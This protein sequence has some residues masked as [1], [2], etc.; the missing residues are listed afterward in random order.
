MTLSAEQILFIR[1]RIDASD[2]R[3]V[4]LKEDVLDHLCCI[5][6]ERMSAGESF[7]KAL[8][9]AL[10]QL[11]PEGLDEIQYETDY[12]FK[13]NTIPMKKFMYSIGLVTS[14]S[15]TMGLMMKLLHMPGG[16]QL[17]NYGFFGFALLFM[18]MLT[19]HLYR[20]NSLRATHEKFKIVLAIVSAALTGLAV[21]F[22][23][24]MNLG[25]SEAMLITGASVFSFGFLPFHFYGMYKK[26][27]IQSAQ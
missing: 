9:H 8:D 14:I 24:S 22:K 13:Q 4:T 26:A 11:S 16:E 25:W 18:P 23:M 6:E 27:L 3:I 17:V 5:V 10:Y 2:M 20:K 1:E 15:F 12:L 7:D 21:L 19:F